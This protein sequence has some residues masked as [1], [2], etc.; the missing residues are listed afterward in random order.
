MLQRVKISALVPA[1]WPEVRR[2]ETVRGPEWLKKPGGSV[3]DRLYPIQVNS[4]AQFISAA[5]VQQAKRYR[6]TLGNSLQGSSIV[7]SKEMEQIVIIP[8]GFQSPL[9]VRDLELSLF[10]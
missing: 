1:S 2:R 5:V 7:I 3:G 6:Q 4:S 10:Q 8:T 9:W